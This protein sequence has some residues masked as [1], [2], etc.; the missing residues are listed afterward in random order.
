[1]KINR[2]IINFSALLF[3]LN[4][5]VLSAQD[6]VDEKIYSVGKTMLIVT[7]LAVIFILWL[8]IVYSEK[9]DSEGKLFKDPVLKIIAFI[10]QS[11]PIEQ[12]QEILLAHNYDGIRELDNK[13]PPWFQ[14][15]RAHV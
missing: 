9:N 2:Y 11:K 13:I 3:L 8:V 4:V 12:E 1:M 6:P 15:G 7:L 10:S 5:N 14:I